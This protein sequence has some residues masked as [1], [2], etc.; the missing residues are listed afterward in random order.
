MRHISEYLPEVLAE[1][2]DRVEDAPLGIDSPLTVWKTGV[3]V[4]SGAKRGY[5]TAVAITKEVAW[6]IRSRYLNRADC[7]PTHTEPQPVLWID[8]VEGAKAQGYREIHLYL[9][10]SRWEAYP[11]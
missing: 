11:L 3:G 6:D 7:Y 9:T 8:V 10:A 2:Y 5:A 1:F 4:K